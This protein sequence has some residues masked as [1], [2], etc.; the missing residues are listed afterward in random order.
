MGTR[1][2]KNSAGGTARLLIVIGG[3]RLYRSSTPGSLKIV[4]LS[5]V[6][7]LVPEAVRTKRLNLSFDLQPLL[8]PRR[9][10]RHLPMP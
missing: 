1:P 7:G 8:S 6:D 5:D 3:D 10:H 9:G 2:P 4:G